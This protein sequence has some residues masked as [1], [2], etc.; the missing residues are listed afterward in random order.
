M[1]S[2]KVGPN[3]ATVVEGSFGSFMMVVA[4]VIIPKIFYLCFFL[5]Q[6]IPGFFCTSTHFQ[7]SPWHLIQ[8]AAYKTRTVTTKVTRFTPHQ[9]ERIILSQKFTHTFESTQKKIV[10]PPATKLSVCFMVAL[11]RLPNGWTRAYVVVVR[12]GL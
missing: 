5:S 4:L 10:K 1:Q 11:G 3:K 6:L 2:F 7:Y 12:D 8:F 9:I